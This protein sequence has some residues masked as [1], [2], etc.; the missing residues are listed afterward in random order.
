MDPGNLL[1]C[2]GERNR[3]RAPPGTTA[4]ALT[5]P[6]LRANCGAVAKFDMAYNANLSPHHYA[7]AHARAAGN[8]AL[9]DNHRIFPDN[10]V[11]CDLN[12]IIDFHTLLYPCP[13]E[14]RP[15]DRRIRADLD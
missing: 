1:L 12:E 5:D 7:L 3:G 11:V 2:F 9:R 14:P 6:A 13:A 8:T 4:G 15:V 10:D